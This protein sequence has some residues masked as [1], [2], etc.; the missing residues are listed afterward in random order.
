MKDKLSE[1]EI[2]YKAIL[3]NYDF[4][5]KTEEELLEVNGVSDNGDLE[6]HYLEI[7]STKKST[8]INTFSDDISLLNECLN[9]FEQIISGENSTPIYMLKVESGSL[10]SK[11]KSENINIS[12]LP[13]IVK[14]FA[15]AMHTFRMTG[16][17]VEYKKSETEL[18]LANADKIRAEAEKIRIENKGTK[19][20]I[21]N[22]RLA[23]M[24]QL[25]H[26]NEEDND[27][28]ELLVRFGISLLDYMEANPQGEMNEIKYD[29]SEC[30]K[31]LEKRDEDRT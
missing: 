1:F 14:N 28:K 21:V 7:R 25:L 20:E 4:L 11:L 29:I 6:E 8:K 27:S 22:S 23:D 13:S 9:L 15:E 3:S 12:I 18:N 30:V 10:F 26:I 2:I 17:E 16:A 19:L 24:M 5:R 31:L